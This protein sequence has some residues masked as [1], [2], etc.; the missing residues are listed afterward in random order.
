MNMH[1]CVQMLRLQLH[2]L[3]TIQWYTGV[4]EPCFLCW[5]KCFV[6]NV[7]L[8]SFVGGIVRGWKGILL[9][10]HRWDKTLVGYRK[11]GKFTCICKK[12]YVYVLKD[13]CR[14]EPPARMCVTTCTY[15]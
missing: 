5:E 13:S 14:M 15:S 3:A 11:P 9:K 12:I 10:R 8:K 1:V 6:F 2:D 4:S 7:M